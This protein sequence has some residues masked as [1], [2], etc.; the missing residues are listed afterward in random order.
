MSIKN[1]RKDYTKFSFDTSRV[2]DNPIDQFRDWFNDAV[3]AGIEDVNA[4]CL[5]TVANNGRPS[6]RI[7]LLKD[8]TD[9]GI[10]FFTNYNSRKGQEIEQN[11][12]VSLCF[13]WKDLERQVRLEGRLEK[14]SRKESVEYFD[15]RPLD[16]RISGIVS[17]QSTVIKNKK[18]LEDKVAELSQHPEKVICPEHW[19][20]YHLVID[21]AEF[22]QGRPN[23]L[24]DRVE[25]ILNSS[26]VWEKRLLAP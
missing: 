20:G 23:R 17:S 8:I 25:Y 11:P 15:S 5:S 18:E 2:K 9:D 1:L 22:W 16:S 19:G 14:I 10:V 21:L 6:S 3:N 7:V 24:H 13:Y 4:M 26:S 12:F